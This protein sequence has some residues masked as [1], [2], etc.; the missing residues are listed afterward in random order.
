MQRSKQIY[1]I[2][3]EL[4]KYNRNI[5]KTQLNKIKCKYK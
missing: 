2:L 3:S 4:E 5:H 1:E